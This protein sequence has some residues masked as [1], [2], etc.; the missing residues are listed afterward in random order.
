MVY[1]K[2]FYVM[3]EA[4]EAWRSIATIFRFNKVLKV[5]YLELFFP[6]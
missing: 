3:L 4:S 5:L 1:K 2:Y 6:S